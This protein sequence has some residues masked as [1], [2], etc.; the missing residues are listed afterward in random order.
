MRTKEM[1][2]DYR[3]FPDPDL[4]PVKMTSH[5]L[6]GYRRASGKTFDKQRRYQEEMNLPY[7]ITSALCGDHL[8]CAYFEE[9]ASLSNLPARWPTGWSMICS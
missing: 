9:A 1:A 2:H 4:M 7:S 3:Y 8:L 6:I 5:G